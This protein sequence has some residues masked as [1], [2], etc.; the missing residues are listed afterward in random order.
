[1]R[2]LML[3]HV[4]EDGFGQLAP[5]DLL[6]AMDR[7]RAFTET[8]AM[9]GALVASGRL[10]PSAASTQ[11]RTVGGRTVTMDGPYAETKEQVGGFY[12]IE[13]DSREAALAL[14]GQCPAVGHGVVELRELQA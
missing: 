8:L 9:A 1:M 12:L 13:A 6:G 14:A 2:Y 4:D 5:A 11:I 3:L 7:Y 10:A